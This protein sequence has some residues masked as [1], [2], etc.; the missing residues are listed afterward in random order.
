MQ[1]EL[2]QNH[3][4]L[5]IKL[6]GINMIGTG[7]GTASFTTSH[8]L[9]MVQDDYTL[10]IWSDWGAQWRDVYVLNENNELVLIYNLTQYSLADI[11]NY[12][13]LK[14]HLIDAAQAMP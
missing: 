13:T 14:Q 10:E 6:F 12:N 3:P 11:N 7:A 8:T 1:T 5:D 4:Q 9:P 2:E